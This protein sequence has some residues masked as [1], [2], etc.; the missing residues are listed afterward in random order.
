MQLVFDLEYFLQELKIYAIIFVSQILYLQVNIDVLVT[1]D[2]L[3]FVAPQVS[4]DLPL[5]TLEGDSLQSDAGPVLGFEGSN[6]AAEKGECQN[7]LD[8]CDHP[9][10]PFSLSKLVSPFPVFSEPGLRKPMS[11]NDSTDLRIRQERRLGTPNTYKTLCCFLKRPLPST[12]ST[13]SATCSERGFENI[14]CME[15]GWFTMAAPRA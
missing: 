9:K 4:L 5:A 15:S 1:L 11:R 13:Q 14:T 3:K 8:I 6:A 2:V 7:N 12:V 10:A